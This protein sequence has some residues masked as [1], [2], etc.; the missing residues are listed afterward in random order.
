M[1][2]YV[3]IHPS[4][5]T[6]N[7]TE[8][9]PKGIQKVLF[10]SVHSDAIKIGN[11]HHQIDTWPCP[12]KKSSHVLRIFVKVTFMARA[13][14]TVRD[15]GV[16]RCGADPRPGIHRKTVRTLQ[17]FLVQLAHDLQ[18]YLPPQAIKRRAGAVV[19]MQM[20]C[21]TWSC[22]DILQYITYY[23][24]YTSY[25]YN[26]EIRER[27]REW[28]RER[29]RLYKI[30]WTFCHVIMTAQLLPKPGSLK[31]CQRP[32]CNGCKLLKYNFKYYSTNLPDLWVCKL[33]NGKSPTIISTFI[34]LWS[35]CSLRHPSQVEHRDRA[36]QSCPQRLEKM[37]TV[38]PFPKSRSMFY[39]TFG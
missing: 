27:E 21:G 7:N 22:I 30:L 31:L 38:S 39:S 19:L 6:L 26:I 29:E 5:V 4:S 28:V 12:W 11:S 33:L 23:I 35:H 3:P 18:T 9:W 14:F 15:A 16:S 1:P 20:L 36:R 34:A 24:I 37:C 8:T 25:V 13:D 10:F 17:S 2:K 32:N